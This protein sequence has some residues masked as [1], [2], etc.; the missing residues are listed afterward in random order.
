MSKIRTLGSFHER[1]SSGPQPANA[2]TTSGRDRA[3]RSRGTGRFGRPPGIRFVFV[4]GRAG[5]QHWIDNPPGL[6]H[7]IFPGEERGVSRHCVSKDSFVSVHLPGARV[8]AGQQFRQIALRFLHRRT[9][10]ETE[11][12]LDVGTDPQPNIVRFQ[13]VVLIHRR[14]LPQVNLNFRAG[15][16][17]ALAGADINGHPA[18]A[19]GIDVEFER[20]KGLNIGIGRDTRLTAVT[21]KLVADEV[22][23]VKWRNGFKDLYLL[24]A[25]GFAIGANRRFHRQVSQDLEEMVLNHVTYGADLFIKCTSTFHAERLR[26][27]DLNAFDVSAVPERFEHGVGK[28]KEQHAV[29]GLFAKIMVNP[30]N[31]L[32]VKGLEQNLIQLSR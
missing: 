24:V 27:R 20:G 3:R 30:E 7:I 13:R 28:A 12:Q 9:H 21:P 2:K 25:D 19:P 26:H 32:L 18:P 23:C 17:Q 22:F 14:R 5:P 6:L 4:Y 29:H 1:G 31:R 11:G 10:I 15:H 16:S 8:P